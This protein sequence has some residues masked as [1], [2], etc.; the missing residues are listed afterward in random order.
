MDGRTPRGLNDRVPMEMKPPIGNSPQAGPATTRRS[1]LRTLGLG[2]VAGPLIL[3]SSTGR[4]AASNR[5][6]VGLI[7]AGARG[8][9]VLKTFLDQSD[10][11][12]LAVSDVH[13]FHYRDREWG[14]GSPMGSEPARDMVEKHYASLSRNGSFQGCAV[15]PDYRDLCVRSDLD[16]VIVGTPDHWHA[17]QVLEALRRG[18]DVYCEKPVT[19]LFAEGVAVY[20]EVARRKAIFQTGSQ[21]RST[22]NFLQA[23]TLVRNGV[24]GKIQEVQ[25]GLPLGYAEPQAD[26]TVVNPPDSLDYNEWCGP[27]PVL[28]YMRARHHRFWRGHSAYGGG[29]LMDWIGHH[30][31]IA[32]WG[33]DMD[34]AGPLTV[35]AVGWT[36]PETRIYDM[37]VDFEVRCTYPGGIRHSISTRHE[38]GTRWIGEKGWV[39]VNRGVTQASNPA[40]L[41]P[42]FQPGPIQP[43]ASPDHTRNFV[44]GVRSRK[45]CVAP[46]ETAHRSI[47]PGHLAFVS[48][49]F[50]RALKWDAAKEQIVGDEEADRWLRRVPYR[51]PWT[52]G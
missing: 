3:S 43:Y 2:S 8:L 30:N 24:I 35:E 45:A 39:Y 41:K 28:R 33:M 50:G 1:F 16:A 42:D 13:P 6:T 12:V 17:L 18:K 11:Q 9:A 4:A 20:Q 25:V 19:H 26:S 31:D 5:V 32:H 44:E 21:Q 36:F 38:M 52:L 10:V 27:A 23:V 15:Y 7:G 22:A 14:K 47:T 40:W 34:G 51:K 49:K 29:N 48:Q 46:A 37:P